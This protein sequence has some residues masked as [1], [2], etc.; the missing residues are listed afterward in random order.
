MCTGVKPAQ[1]YL[2][3]VHMAAGPQHASMPLSQGLSVG[4][5]G[6]DWCDTYERDAV[7][8][9]ECSRPTHCVDVSG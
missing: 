9:S 8:S 4:A 6:P 3:C 5:T 1:R 2:K 7:E